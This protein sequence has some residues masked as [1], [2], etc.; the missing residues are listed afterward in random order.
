MWGFGR[1]ESAVNNIFGELFG[2]NAV[3]ALM[4]NANLDLRKKLD[5][6]AVGLK[7]KGLEHHNEIL[8]RVHKL[9]DIRNAIVHSEFYEEPAYDGVEFDYVTKHGELR[10]PHIKPRHSG[11]NTLITYSDFVSFDE[12][13]AKL[14]EY[15]LSNLEGSLTPITEFS[16]SLKSEIA[17]IISSADKV[18]PF[19][20]RSPDSP[21]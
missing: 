12:E 1:I 20:R 9:A 4:I 18:I 14:V 21:Q 2:L 8:R 6:I 15:V 3:V 19:P 5:L 17:D 11:Y 16:D 10:L 13:A 7:H